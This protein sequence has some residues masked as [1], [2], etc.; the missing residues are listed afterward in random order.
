VYTFEPTL[1]WA[2][3]LLPLLGFLINGS[4]SLFGARRS[5]REALARDPH[6]R[7]LDEEPG[8]HAHDDLAPATGG[9]RLIPTIVG[10]GVVGLAFVIA[11]VNFFRMLGADLHEPI[12]ETY[13]QWIPVG[14]LHI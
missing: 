13:F 6:G 1:L 5:A 7:G 8:H 3:A 9:S 14:S 12:I 11:L 2:I 4:V 10:P